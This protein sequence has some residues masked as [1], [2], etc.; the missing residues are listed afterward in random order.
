MTDWVKFYT[1]ALKKLG[2]NVTAVTYSPDPEVEDD[3]ITVDDRV[4]IQ[5]GLGYVVVSYW[6][7]DG[8]LQCYP[9]RNSSFWLVQDLQDALTKADINNIPPEGEAVRL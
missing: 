4:F 6:L 3:S 5:V 9:A 8:A 1:S 7:N 2:F